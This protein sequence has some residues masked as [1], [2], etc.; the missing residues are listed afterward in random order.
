MSKNL[1]WTEQTR[2][3]YQRHLDGK[4]CEGCTIVPKLETMKKCKLIWEVIEIYRLWGNPELSRQE[5]YELSGFKRCGN[6]D[7]I[8]PLSEFNVD[9]QGR[10]ITFCKQCEH[11]KKEKKQ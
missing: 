9:K 5:S 11:K 8:K 3:C 6:C 4:T 10:S 2:D 1:I 7:K